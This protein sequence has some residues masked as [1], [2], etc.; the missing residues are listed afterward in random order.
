MASLENVSHEKIRI[1][2]KKSRYSVA[3]PYLQTGSLMMRG[4]IKYTGVAA[5][6]VFRKL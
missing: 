2:K 6:M 1:R 4:R 3:A 5:R